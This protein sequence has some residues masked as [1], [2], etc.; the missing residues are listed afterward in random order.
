MAKVKADIL[1]DVEKSLDA[2]GRSPQVPEDTWDYQKTCAPQLLRAR[3]GI[4]VGK[5][6][7]INAKS[8]S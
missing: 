5:L 1:G 2:A 8:A 4:I 6:R 7:T 3:V